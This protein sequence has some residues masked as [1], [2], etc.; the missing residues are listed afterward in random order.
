MNGCC[1]TAAKPRAGL[2]NPG[3][4]SSPSVAALLQFIRR[5]TLRVGTG[6]NMSLVTAYLQH[7]H[8]ASRGPRERFFI[9]LVLVR[10]LYPRAGCR[11]AT[12]A[13]WLPGWSVARSRGGY[14]RHLLLA[15]AGAADRYPWVSTSH[16]SSR[17][18]TVRAP[19]PAAAFVTLR[20]SLLLMRRPS[21]PG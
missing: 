12:G 15:L 2:R 17:R 4:P 7:E 13:R 18:N 20:V 11:A 21:R 3:S 5:P 14:H 1:M 8:L 10:V 6:H 19:G 16:R 9:N